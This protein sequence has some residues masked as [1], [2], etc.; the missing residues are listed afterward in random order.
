MT[1]TL[2]LQWL[3][4]L[5]VHSRMQTQQRGERLSWTVQQERARA[6][7]WSYRERRKDAKATDAQRQA[8]GLPDTVPLVA[9]S[10]DDA[11]LAALMTFGDGRGHERTQA[12]RRQLIEGGD[13][14]AAPPGKGRPKAVATA[15]RGQ[16]PTAGGSRLAVSSS[17]LKRSGASSSSAP[18]RKPGGGGAVL[19]GDSRLKVAASKARRLLSLGVKLGL[20]EPA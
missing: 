7:A 5:Q 4:L 10:A 14:F 2:D 19:G 17:A 11:R 18:S 12:V 1:S 9:E 8:L 13:I 15:Q 3:L 6:R 20:S 16:P